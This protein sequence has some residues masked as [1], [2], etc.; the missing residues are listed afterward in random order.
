MYFFLPICIPISL[1]FFTSLWTAFDGSKDVVACQ[2][3][4]H[5]NIT[6]QIAPFKLK[7]VKH[8]FAEGSIHPQDY[9]E[10]VFTYVKFNKTKC[11]YDKLTNRL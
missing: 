3:A 6:A 9:D 10:D 7:C 11:K 1:I 8:G 5:G 4:R 2:C